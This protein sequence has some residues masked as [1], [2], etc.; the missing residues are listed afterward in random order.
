MILMY[1]GSKESKRWNQIK[2]KCK[3][4]KRGRWGKM[5]DL[6]EVPIYAEAHGSLPAIFF[7]PG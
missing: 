4:A 1:A 6:S 2:L 5:H 3:F 7:L